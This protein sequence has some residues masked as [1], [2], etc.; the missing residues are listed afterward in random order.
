LAE[1]KKMGF[2]DKFI[3]RLWGTNGLAVYNLRH[4]NGVV[5]VFKMVDTAHVGCQMLF[6]PFRKA[7]PF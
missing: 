3:A 5:P 1:A 4:E 7:Q 6:R 2:S